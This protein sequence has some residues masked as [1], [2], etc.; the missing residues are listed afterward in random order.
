[1]DHTHMITEFKI[2]IY[3]L[4]WFKNGYRMA[5]EW[6]QNG[7]YGYKGFELKVFMVIMAISP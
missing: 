2:S 4:K 1:M 5:I 3:G 6:L 7:Y